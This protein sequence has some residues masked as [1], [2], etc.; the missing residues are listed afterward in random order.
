VTEREDK[1]GRGAWRTGFQRLET[2]LGAAAILIGSATLAP[3]AWI[4]WILWGTTVITLPT[5]RLVLLAVAALLLAVLVWPWLRPSRRPSA[6]SDK[7]RG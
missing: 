6:G 4:E 7:D 3:D 5:A 2:Q 1:A